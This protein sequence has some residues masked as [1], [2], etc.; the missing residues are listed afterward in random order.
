M[1]RFDPAVIEADPARRPVILGWLESALEAIAPERLTREALARWKGDSAAVIAIGKASP[2]MMRGAVQAITL[3]GAIAV[4]DHSEGDIPGVEMLIGDHPVPGRRSELAGT[5]VLNYVR[6]LAQSVPLIALI[7]GG[8]SAL[9]ESPRPGLTMD[10]VADVGNRMLLAGADITEIN[11][12][13][14]HL[15]AIKRGGIA[16]AAG[17][18]IDTW[19]I[20]DVAG[21]DAGT[22]ASGPTIW[23]PP[24][25]EGALAVMGRYHVPVSDEAR[26]AIMAPSAPVP[27]GE[28]T[29][30]A[31][32]L[33]AAKALAATAGLPCRIRSEWIRGPVAANLDALF[34][35]AESGLNIAVGEASLEVTGMGAGGRNTHAALLAAER[36]PGSDQVFIALAT[37]GVDG[38]S[39]TAGAI[40]DGGTLARGGD[41]R[42]ALEGFDSASYLRRSGDTL[43]CPPT[44]TNVADLWILWNPTPS[45]T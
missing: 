40:V 1:T 12:V 27:S 10:Y 28:I 29:M 17:R 9:C 24:D 20:S 31:D 30:L 26:A 3:Q 22:V 11:L 4:G 44:G 15:S 19:V 18:P 35:E 45:A 6:G 37:D 41:P 16:H 34:E 21:A 14:G 43:V 32:G 36:L 42:A 33:D 23:K 5:R 39:G 25:P 7:S 8:G 38:S 2:P 13:R